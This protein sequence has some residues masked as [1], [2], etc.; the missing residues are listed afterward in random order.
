MSGSPNLQLELDRPVGKK[1]H[2]PIPGVFVDEI[3]IALD[4][5]RRHRRK[6]LLEKSSGR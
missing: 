6:F 1:L 5:F 3:T 2:I 4:V